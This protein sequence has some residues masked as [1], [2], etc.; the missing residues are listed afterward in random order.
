MEMVLW[1]RERIRMLL[2][3]WVLSGGRFHSIL[4]IGLGR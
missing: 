1:E 4:G 3:G 2:I